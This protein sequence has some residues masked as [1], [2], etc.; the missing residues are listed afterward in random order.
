MAAGI[1]EKPHFEMM[2]NANYTDWFTPATGFVVSQAT[3]RQVER[4]LYYVYING[5]FTSDGTT[6]GARVDRI[7][8]YTGAVIGTV[9]KTYFGPSPDG[10]PITGY[11]PTLVAEANDSAKVRSAIAGFTVAGDIQIRGANYN[12]CYVT[13]N[14]VVVRREI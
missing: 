12:T 5:Y 8:A 2:Y 10:L 14:G 11:V 13:V 1:I 4:N 3:I 7:T 6:E 9:K